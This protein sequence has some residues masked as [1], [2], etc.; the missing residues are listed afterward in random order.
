MV[1]REALHRQGDEQGQRTNSGNTEIQEIFV[2]RFLI[3]LMF[4]VANKRKTI[5]T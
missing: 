5:Q 3:V 2:E 1:G 4:H